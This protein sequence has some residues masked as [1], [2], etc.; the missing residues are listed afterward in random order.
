[1]VV[2]DFGLARL[3]RGSTTAPVSG[4]LAGTPEYWAPEQACR[5]AR[6]GPPRT[7]TRSAASSSSSSRGRLPFEGEDRLATGL[8]RAHEPAPSLAHR[9][10]DAPAEA[11]RLVDRLLSAT[12]RS[13][14]TPP[15]SALALGA[16]PASLPGRRRS[17]RRGR[18]QHGVARRRS[19]RACFREPAT[20]VQR[21]RTQ[22]AVPRGRIAAAR[23]SCSRP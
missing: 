3:V 5:S 11:V 7:S 20:I 9:R 23:R 1:M 18:T 19:S 4:V 12:P 10:P 8:R 14:A 2:T 21:V 6:P 13:G 22:R 17:R 16:D 15:T